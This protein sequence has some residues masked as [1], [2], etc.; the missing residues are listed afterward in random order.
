LGQ[1]FVFQLSIV[2]SL[3]SSTYLWATLQTFLL[4]CQQMKETNTII[5]GQG[6]AGSLTAFMLHQQ[7]IPFI[8]IDASYRN[9]A[10]KIAAGMFTPISG[11]RNTIDPIMIEQTNFAITIYKQIEE[12]IGQTIL[13]IQNIYQISTSAKQQNDLIEKGKTEKFKKYIIT[14]P[15]ILPGIKQE[16]G[17]IEITNSGW[18]NC[19]LFI[20]SF[21]DWLKQKDAFI[22][23]VFS[24]NELQIKN[25]NLKYKNI[26]FKNIIFCEGY[27]AAKNP[28]FKNENLIPCKGDILTIEYK[29]DPLNHIIKKNACYLIQ[30]NKNTFKAGSTYQ[31]HNDS[32]TLEDSNKIEIA[33]KITAILNNDFTITDHQTAIRPTTKNREVIAKQHDQHSN[34]FMLN[35][36][37]TK[38][39][40]QAPWWVNHII[41]LIKNN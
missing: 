28:F 34:I 7:N 32:E 11:Q 30:S 6:I 17:S 26:Q 16:T 3:T 5:V 33:T 37:G 14:N 40:I 1:A 35:G 39:I 10:S 36:L 38:G 31:W 21:N 24:Y 15:E 12:L 18:V 9:T 8:V 27:R 20:N 25:K 4:D 19:P 23:E 13:H 2:V 29:T 41:K 22:Q